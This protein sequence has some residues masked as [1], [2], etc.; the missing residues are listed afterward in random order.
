MEVTEVLSERELDRGFSHQVQDLPGAG[1]LEKCIQC[2]TCSGSCQMSAR[3]DY[4][5]RRLIEMA[6]V[7]MKREVLSSRAIWYCASCYSCT[8][9]CPRGINITE[10]M[11][12]LKSLAIKNEM[13]SRRDDGPAF[14]TSFYDVIKR[15][16]RL[17]EGSVIAGFAWK[18]NPWR[19]W[20]MAPLGWKMFLSGNLE[21]LPEKIKKPAEISLLLE[22]LGGGVMKR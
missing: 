13:C 14:Y 2:G 19:L 4:T 20:G 22:K 3:M 6:R 17:H 21:V 15:Y 9:R 7:G 1:G 18:T 8:V 16:G 10:V 11:S 12:G 5:P